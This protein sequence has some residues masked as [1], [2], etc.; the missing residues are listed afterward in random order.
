MKR[1]DLERIR[2]IHDDKGLCLNT[3]SGLSGTISDGNGSVTAPVTILLDECEKSLKKDAEITSLRAQLAEARRHAI[4]ECA[5]LAHAYA[6][7][8]AKEGASPTLNA[9]KMMAHAVRQVERGLRDIASL[10]EGE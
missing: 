9:Y 1:D 7:E 2:K 5:D 4:A 3:A 10:K 6:L 8:L